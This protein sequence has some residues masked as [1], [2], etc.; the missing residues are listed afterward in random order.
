MKLIESHTKKDMR[1]REWQGVQERMVCVNVI[2]IYHV[3]L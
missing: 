2:E 3:H 1:V